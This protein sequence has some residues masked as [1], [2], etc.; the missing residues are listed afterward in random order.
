M[1]VD[2]PVRADCNSIDAFGLLVNQPAG[3]YR[4]VSLGFG[5][6][7]AGPGDPAKNSKISLKVSAQ[8]LSL[9]TAVNHKTSDKALY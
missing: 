2:V 9:K 3:R 4:E 6:K 7:K 8:I 1:L 5:N